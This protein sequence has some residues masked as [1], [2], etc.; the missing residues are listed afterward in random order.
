MLWQVGWVEQRRARLSITRLRRRHRLGVRYPPGRPC[1]RHV[2]DPD[3]DV[4]W[5]HRLL[6]DREQVLGQAVEVNLIA[7]CRTESLE[8]ACRIVLAPVEAPVD[9][10]LDPPPP[11]VE[12]R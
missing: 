10:R 9:E 2:P 7:Q 3:R 4:R 5:L 11:G 1:G 6:D 8:R 12:E